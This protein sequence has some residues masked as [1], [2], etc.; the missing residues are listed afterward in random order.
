MKRLIAILLLAPALAI[1]E[2]TCPAPAE[3]KSPQRDEEASDASTADELRS[4]AAASARQQAHEQ[5]VARLATELGL[6]VE[7]LTDRFAELNRRAEAAAVDFD[8]VAA[9]VRLA[10]NQHARRLERR[11]DLHSLIGAALLMIDPLSDDA[12]RAPALL[13]RA[14]L[15]DSTDPAVLWLALAVCQV[16]SGECDGLDAAKVLVRHQPDNI[17]AWW[18]LAAMDWKSRLDA[19]TKALA[20]ER[21]DDGQSL[22]LPILVEAYAGVD[23]P[24][25][26]QADFERVISGSYGDAVAAMGR[27]APL[28]LRTRQISS[29]LSSDRWMHAHCTHVSSEPE[30]ALADG[31]RTHYQR[32]AEQSVHSE[33]LSSAYGMLRMDALGDAEAAAWERR[34]L[35]LAWLLYRFDLAL[36]EGL[37]KPDLDYFRTLASEGDLEAIRRSLTTA[38]L[39]VEP[40][41]DF[42]FSVASRRWRIQALR[43]GP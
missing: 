33:A 15:L 23:L 19:T 10:V 39:P 3:W 36:E 9:Q 27:F 5:A 40:P 37:I 24:T 30:S 28:W 4:R 21:F 17:A 8:R 20:A 11:G 32:V 43:L 12:G 14:R 13:H 7:E 25:T 18:L 16:S 1:A 38:G 2:V 29:L 41:D 31:C 35:T 42:S 22:L 34:D 26:V 6:T